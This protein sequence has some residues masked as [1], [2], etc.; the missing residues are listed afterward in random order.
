MFMSHGTRFGVRSAGGFDLAVNRRLA[1][2]VELGLEYM[3]NPG[4]DVQH[5]TLLIPAV[6][7]VARL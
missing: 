2:I 5:R 1:V 3:L 4:S 7:A 6:G